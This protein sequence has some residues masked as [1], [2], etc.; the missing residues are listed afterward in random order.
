M[1]LLLDED[2]VLMG[3]ELTY[4]DKKFGPDN[5]GNDKVKRSNYQTFMPPNYNNY[6]NPYQN[7][8]MNQ[9]MNNY[10]YQHNMYP[11]QNHQMQYQQPNV[12]Y[13]PDYQSS[14]PQ[15]VKN[16]QNKE[17]FSLIQ[18]VLDDKPKEKLKIPPRK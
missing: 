14:K 4:I 8:G 2:S 15:E 5:A 18:E 16:D 12:Y 13:P 3:R 17:M 9:P 1:T 11:P 10:G 7:M 6:M